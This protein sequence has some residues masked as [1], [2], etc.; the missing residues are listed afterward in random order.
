[1]NNDILISPEATEASFSPSRLLILVVAL[2]LVLIAGVVVLIICLTSARKK[3]QETKDDGSYFDGSFWQLIGYRILSALVCTV[4]LSIAYPWMHCMVQ[5]WEARHT[6]INGRR[7][8]FTGRG[9]QLV[10]KYLLWIF[11]TVI[12]FGIYGIWLGLRMKKWTVKHTVYAD[13]EHPAE[14]WFSGGAGGYL[15]IHLLAA[16]LTVITFG[17]GKAWADKK[18][19]A[20]EARHTHI[21]GSPLVFSGSGGQLFGKYVLLVILTPLTLGI[22]G[23][24]FPVILTKW[25]ISHTDA[26]YR[27]AEI[28]AKARSHEPIA[29]QNY[30]RYKLAAND[31]EIASLK[32]GYTGL[33]DAQTLEHMAEAGNPFAAYRLAC[34]L[35]G[36]APRFEG[37]ALELLQAAANRKVHFALLDFAKQLPADQKLPMLTEAAQHGSAEACWLLVDECQHAGDWIQA[38]YWFRVALEWGHAEAAQNQTAYESLIRQIALQLSED[39]QAPKENKA[40]PIVLG[41]IGAIV[42]LAGIGAILMTR[43]KPAEKVEQ[44]I[45]VDRVETVRVWQSAEPDDLQADHI[46][47]LDHMGN[48]IEY[49]L[50]SEAFLDREK[51]ILYLEFGVIQ[52]AYDLSFY[53]ELGDGAFWQTHAVM[54]SGMLEIAYPY[55]A[56]PAEIAVVDYEGPNFINF[57]PVR[58]I[59]GSTAEAQAW[60]EDRANVIQQSGTNAHNPDHADSQTPGADDTDRI[61]GQW[62][63]YDLYAHPAT[64]ED[65]LD[66][67]NFTFC[68]DGTYSFTQ[69]ECMVSTEGNVYYAGRCWMAVLGYGLDGTYE[70][71][72]NTLTILYYLD[73][74]NAIL[75]SSEY[76]VEWEDHGLSLYADGWKNPRVF[77]HTNEADYSANTTASIVGEWIKY[78]VYQATGTLAMDLERWVFQEDGT[79]VVYMEY[80]YP[81]GEGATNLY[82]DDLY[83]V[84]GSGWGDAGTYTFDGARL[85]MTTT[86]YDPPDYSETIVSAY[87][88]QIAGDTLWLTY[89]DGTV[90]ELTKNSG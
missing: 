73:G 72:G 88:V 18:V 76:S 26:R 11:L 83:W 43:S 23:L 6:V 58:I 57:H 21:G 10:G 29:V 68:A 46:T 74:E 12:T 9:H 37:K 3:P 75:S 67:W 54:Q 17:I 30:A 59:E 81:S 5:R 60:L 44:I 49:M 66:I 28:Q 45:P 61:I 64:G 82:V 47:A 69:E 56:L 19:M 86:Y 40:L 39:G 16:L 31:Q 7:L 48:T 53:A 32:S 50:S 33:E 2:G 35:K 13:E 25:R 55:T 1:M 78:D 34:V 80:C 42:L 63:H 36:E 71:T 20:W 65:T 52:T 4:T 8:K 70:L 89:A 77:T 15:G 87:D 41:I 27:T 24:C 38:A 62:V 51:N 79:C 90:K 22:Y 84:V 85:E 14:S